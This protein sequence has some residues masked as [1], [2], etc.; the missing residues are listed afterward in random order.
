[1]FEFALIFQTV[2]ITKTIT[3][4]SDKDQAIGKFK[5]KLNSS[6]MWHSE[7]K[8]PKNESNENAYKTC[9]DAASAKKHCPMRWKSIQKWAEVCTTLP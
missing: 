1:M 3:G 9:I 8:F 6:E 2:K 5:E 4:L 7:T